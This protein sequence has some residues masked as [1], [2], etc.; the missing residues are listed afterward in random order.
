MSEQARRGSIT[1]LDASVPAKKTQAPPPSPDIVCQFECDSLKCDPRLSRCFTLA[2][3]EWRMPSKNLLAN[4]IRVTLLPG[5]GLAWRSL[6]KPM[7]R[8]YSF[9][10]NL[11]PV[12]LSHFHDLR[13]DR[14]ER[15]AAIEFDVSVCRTQYFLP[16][17]QRSQADLARASR[18]HLFSIW[19]IVALG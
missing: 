10:H 16:K 13:R 12:S 2:A 19:K 5:K 15:F 3:I 11:R 8:Q 1:I 17:S 18:Q 6:N 7:H 9:P 4:L 14:V